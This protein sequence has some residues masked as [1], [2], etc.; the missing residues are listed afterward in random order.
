MVKLKKRA[1]IEGRRVGLGASTGAGPSHW[2]LTG[3]AGVGDGGTLLL[4]LVLVL[5]D[6]TRTR[7]R[8]AAKQR[9]V[10]VEFII[11]LLLFLALLLAG[12]VATSDPCAVID[13]GVPVDLATGLACLDSIPFNATRLNATVATLINGMQLY[14]FLDIAS[15]PPPPFDAVDLLADLQ[16]L[17]SQ[18]FASDLRMHVAIADVFRR[19]GDAHTRYRPPA[20][21]FAFDIYWPLTLF[22]FAD[23]TSGAPV[24]GVVDPLGVAEGLYPR[25][26]A[27][28]AVLAAQNAAWGAGWTSRFAD[29]A[30][31]SID[32]V[33]A[34]TALFA[35]ANSSVGLSKSSETRAFLGL[36]KF[37][38]DS[39]S[40][41]WFTK[42]NVNWNSLPAAAGH[43]VVLQLQGSNKTVTVQANYSL[44]ASYDVVSSKLLMQDCYDSST[45]A[46]ERTRAAK[47]ADATLVDPPKMRGA[48]AVPGW[49]QVFTDGQFV[50]FWMGL[51]KGN[52]ATLAMYLPTFEIADTDVRKF[53]NSLRRGFQIGAAYGATKLIIELE[54]NGGGN[55]C[56]GLALLNATGLM[57][58]QV[59]SD[60][61]GSPLANAMAVGLQNSTGFTW[62][63]SSYT[64][65]AT[66]QQFTN[67]SWLVPGVVKVRG[68]KKRTYSQLLHLSDAA[69]GADAFPFPLT[70][71]NA[72]QISIVTH[73]MCGSTCALFA[74][75]A[76]RYAHVTTTVVGVHDPAN[77]QLCSFPGLQVVEDSEIFGTIAAAGVTGPLVPVPV[78][79]G[80][81]RACIREI[82]GHND[83]NTPIEYRWLPADNAILPNRFDAKI[84]G[85]YW[86]RL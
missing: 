41:G 70:T 39:T 46:T 22:G 36:T 55:I 5:A 11:M 66:G 7:R 32:G 44:V 9:R 49:R 13:A 60:M 26:H 2:P 17:T 84:F 68:G 50:T 34:W 30:V 82:Y 77:Q 38:A 57:V 35:W 27:F 75:H 16:A 56:V 29:A 8:V 81:W 43:T 12:A 86:G 19:L 51:S 3:G 83:V 42:L 4:V 78:P 76:A 33:D 64:S 52:T 31:V 10:N 21:Y 47:K 28:E 72:S 61:P 14:T 85:S 62:S 53:A 6:S 71:F 54:N 18:T 63:P 25:N 20:C 80:T 67:A 65:V 45:T 23:D 79:G 58:D 24:L 37:F 69:C 74:L 59:K 48:Q 15:N 40:L 1:A 73:G